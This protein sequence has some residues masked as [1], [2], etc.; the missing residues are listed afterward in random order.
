MGPR[1]Q[2][3]SEQQLVYLRKGKYFAKVTQL[4]AVWFIIPSL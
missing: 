3:V 1:V 4:E 2:K